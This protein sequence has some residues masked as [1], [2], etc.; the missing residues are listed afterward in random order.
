MD[1]PFPPGSPPR[2]A[3]PLA[4]F[5]PPLE[6]GAV[7]RALAGFGAPGDRVLDP[8]GASPRL[9]AACARAGRAVLVAA[10]NPINRFLLE[11]TLEPFS[12]PELQAA[13]ARLAAAPM[14]GSRLEPFL[15]ELYRSECGHCGLDVIVD[16]FVWEK[17]AEGPELKGYACPHC[18]HAGEDI[19]SQAD[20]ERAQAYSRRGMQHAIALEQVA[21][22]GDPDRPHAEAALAVYPGRALYALTTLTRKLGQLDFEPRMRAAAEALLLSAFEAA[23]ALWGHPEGRPRPLQLSASP[24]YREANVWRALER[25]LVEWSLDPPGVRVETWNP[26]RPPESGVVA[27]FAGPVRDLAGQAERGMVQSVVTVLP[28]PNQAYW[29]LSALWAAWLWGAEAAGPIKVA[30]RRRRYDW[31]WHAAALRTTFLGVA[32]CLAERTPVLA[33]IPEAEGGFL[34]AAL[35]AL[36]AAGFA[37]RGRALRAGEDQAVLVWEA[38]GPAAGAPPLEGLEARMARAAAESLRTRGEPAPYLAVH[39]AAWT[40]L[41]RDRCLG[42]NWKPDEPNPLGGLVDAFERAL[43]R[44]E[45]FVRWGA[46]AEPETGLYWLVDPEW[47]ALPLA[48]RVESL[49]MEALSESG[50]RPLLEI[51]TAVCEALPGLHTPDRRLI[52]SCLRSYAVEH[53]EAG[54]W[55]LRP[56]DQ[57][58]ARLSDC[59][60]VLGLLRDLG[61]RLGYQTQGDEP[62]VWSDARGERAYAFRVRANA[63]LGALLAAEGPPAILV[64]PGGRA[65]LVAEMARRDPRL[66]AFLERGR[67]VKFRHVRRLAA[68]TTLRP[69][70]FAER[71]ALDPPEHRDPQLPLL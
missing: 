66:R 70:N 56:E 50:E 47:A 59:R 4:R 20:W 60:E 29:T 30:L 1:L 27:V 46:G 61:R 28:R 49:V 68:E 36:D 43:E 8:F 7:E 39:A 51:E 2:Q 31:G 37:L 17:D 34:A 42:P 25:G 12:L 11:H 35:S 18:N 41:A 38:A 55:R 21:P 19:A 32:P 15:L 33:F 67:V 23:N 53:P 64:L 16:Y 71:L 65:S 58:A 10:N 40:D 45:V 13:L 14:D 6:D 63:G 5:I 9:A 48:D 52:L 3:G 24:H 54:V 62:I 26:A 57:R 69:E 44:R 22:R